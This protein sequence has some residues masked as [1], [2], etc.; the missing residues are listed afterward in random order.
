M[1]ELNKFHETKPFTLEDWLKDKTQVCLNQKGEV[2]DVNTLSVG[3]LTDPEN[4]KNLCLQPAP[5]TPFELLVEK[6]LQEAAERAA[7]KGVILSCGMN[8]QNKYVRTVAKE[9]M[10]EAIK[11]YE[12]KMKK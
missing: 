3:Y 11:E 7:R 2:L 9:L 8:L 6:K 5:L 4:T 10:E 12:S 1:E